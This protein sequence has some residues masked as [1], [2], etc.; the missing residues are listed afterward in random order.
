M[1]AC[2]WVEYEA[3]E[4]MNGIEPELGRA[5]AGHWRYRFAA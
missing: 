1:L 5:G 4:K 2:S 3:L